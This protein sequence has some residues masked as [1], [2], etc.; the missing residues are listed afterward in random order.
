MGEISEMVLDGTLC[1]ICGGLMEDLKPDK[2]NELLDPPGYPRACPACKEI[3]DPED[4]PDWNI[5]KDAG[6]DKI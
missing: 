2:G 3:P 6:L 1:Q 4:E 5:G